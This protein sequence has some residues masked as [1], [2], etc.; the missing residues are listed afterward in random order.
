MSTKKRYRPLWVILHWLMAAL[1]FATFG[2]GLFSLAYKPNVPEKLGP[3]SIHMALG[4]AILLIVIARY[5]LRLLVFRPAQR[6]AQA[7]V[8]KRKKQPI[9]DQLSVYVHPLLYL[10]TALMA[11]LGI[12]I[13]IPANLLTTIFTHSGAALPTDFYIYPAR[14]WHGT[15]SLILLLLIA[16]HVLVAIFHQFLK[17]ENFLGRM[18]FIKEVSH[19]ISEKDTQ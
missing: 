19:P 14:A 15:L 16:Q 12:A 6:A 9:L 10:F 7:S 13:A 8:L 3:L 4:I 5:I 1:V 17:G 18:W 2:I 11:L